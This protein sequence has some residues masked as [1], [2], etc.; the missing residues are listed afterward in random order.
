MA[1]HNGGDG[2]KSF[3]GFF[4]FNNDGKVSSFE[5]W[6]GL[7]LIQEGLK[8]FQASSSPASDDWFFS[9]D[10]SWRDTCEDS[11]EY[12]LN[13]DDFETEEEYNDALEDAKYGWRDTCESGIE[14]SLDPCDFETED[15]YNEALEEAKY[16]WRDICED[17][18]E[19]DL[20]PGDFETEDEYNEALE[21]A[22]YAWRDTC[23]DGSEYDLDPDD[24]E[25]AEEYN[26]ALSAAKEESEED[27]EED[28][29]P[30][31]FFAPQQT[32][33]D[34]DPR[35]EDYPDVRRYR[36][37]CE[38]ADELRYGRNSDESRRKQACCRFILENADTLV[39]ARYLDVQGG[40]LYAQ[41][42]KDHFTLPI[43]LPDEETERE[44]EF[45]LIIRKI[46]KRNIALSF[47]VWT[48]CLEQFLPYA[49]H[50]PYAAADMTTAVADDLY[51]FPKS[52]PVRLV[53]Y[54][55]EHPDICR[56][57]AGSDTEGMCELCP[58]ITEAIQEGL[59]QTAHLLFSGGLTAAGDNWKLICGF[60]GGM[61]SWCKN[62][63]EL[64]TIEFFRDALLPLV[65]AIPIGMV[66]DEINDWEQEIVAYVALME[67]ECD[68]YAYSRKY[69]WRA[70]VPSGK[71]YDLDPIDYDTEQAYLAALEEEKYGWRRWYAG[72]DTLG[73]DV[74]NY[75]TEA[76]FDRAYEAAQRKK[77]QQERT[78]WEKER[79]EQERQRT[80][81][82]KKAQQEKRQR[83]KAAA[84]DTNIYTICGVTLSRGTRIYHYLVGDNDLHAG[85]RVLVPAG[86]KTATGTVVSIGQ[87]LRKAAPFPLEQMKTVLGKAPSNTTKGDTHHE[88]QK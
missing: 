7:H 8:Q 57:I 62:Y 43:S 24:F 83:E 87:Y 52:Y 53:H 17:G 88:D 56:S 86:G 44:L 23:E 28:S 66:Q 6:L 70:T 60:A 84:A 49:R 73:L 51:N 30:F 65:K 20:D 59:F 64:E 45:P 85:D 11:I 72:R 50:D 26:E 4:D 22:K 14:Y 67:D 46:A 81:Q 48:W 3:G 69:A 18:S 47:E 61:V 33:S 25:T 58:L 68:K 15:E 2:K 80:Q 13:P 42:V 40:F 63:D 5:S 74:M 75:E 37:A 21:E 39:A 31:V 34:K 77:E 32:V 10:Y 36:A 54:L 16:A 41:A 9:P 29:R 79:K 71:K 12:G 76:A 78:Q 1:K 38:L 82:R 19:Y 35:P 55:D 27:E